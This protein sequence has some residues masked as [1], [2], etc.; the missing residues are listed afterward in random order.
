[1]S[2]EYCSFKKGICPIASFTCFKG[3]EKWCAMADV[4]REKN[5]EEKEETNVILFK[6]REEV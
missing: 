3:D 2:E 4:L 5:K 1:M 6:K